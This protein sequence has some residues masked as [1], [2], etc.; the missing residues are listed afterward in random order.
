MTQFAGGCLCGA[1]RYEVSAAP[2]VAL[3]CHCRDCQY[4]SGGEPADA[5]VVPLAGLRVTRGEP[6]AFWKAADSGTRV[7]RS[8]CADCGTPLFSGNERNPALVAIKT[9]SLDT[10]SL[11]PPLGHIW[12]SSAQP[13]HHLDPGQPAFPRNPPM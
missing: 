5:V 8:F 3:R 2:L 4:V 1:I 10:P 12:T 6:R 13:W 11:Y 9:G 7:Y